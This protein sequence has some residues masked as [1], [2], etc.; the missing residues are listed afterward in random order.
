MA[1]ILI[2]E[3][4]AGVRLL[5]SRALGLE[6]HEVT[7]AEDGEMALDVLVERDGA[8]DFVLSDIR[9][10]CLTGIELA[11]EIAASWPHLP[12]LL[13]TGYAEQMEAAEDLTAIIE[14]VVEKP[15]S[16]AE[17][18]REVARILAERAQKGDATDAPTAPHIRR[19]A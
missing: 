12:V 9:M 15:F 1:R 10:P 13:M 5:V 14:G 2:A 6:G 4:D 7:V 17:L 19:C 16:I 18:R 8:F 11:H 3:D